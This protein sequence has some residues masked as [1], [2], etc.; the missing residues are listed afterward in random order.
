MMTIYLIFVAL[1]A[2]VLAKGS[3]ECNFSDSTGFR[4]CH[5]AEGQQLIFHLSNETNTELRLI[6]DAKYRIFKK[7]KNGTVTLDEAYICPIFQIQ[8]GKLNLG[9]ATKRHAG[10]YRLEEYGFDDGKIMKQAELNLTIHALISKPTVSQ[11]CF[12]SQ[13]RAITCSSKEDGAEFLLTV[14]DNILIQSKH[15]RFLN[16]TGKDSNVSSVSINIHGQLTGKFVCQVRNNYCRN[17]TVFH[18]M[19]CK[20]SD[21]AIRVLAFIVKFLLLLAFGLLLIKCVKK[22]KNA[23]TSKGTHED[24]IVYSDIKMLENPHTAEPNIQEHA[25]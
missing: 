8:K 17:E 2:M 18:L 13:V 19:A 10:Q 11:V 23:P 25:E 5:G 21:T 9:T 16:S 1:T 14:D 22:T 20:G 6:K 15:S 3:T 24:E 7:T 12:S 4:Q